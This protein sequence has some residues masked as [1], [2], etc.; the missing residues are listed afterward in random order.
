MNPYGDAIEDHWNP[1]F[2]AQP[3]GGDARYE[4]PNSAYWRPHESES[5]PVA[6]GHDTKPPLGYSQTRIGS[7][8]TLAYTSA[9]DAP[10]W[11]VPTRAMSYGHI[12]TLAHHDYQ[13]RAAAQF[14]HPHTLDTSAAITSTTISTPLSAPIIGHGMPNYGYQQQWNSVY[15][16]PASLPSDSLQ[17]Q[18]QAFAPQFYPTNNPHSLQQMKEEHLPGTSQYAGTPGFYQA[19]DSQVMR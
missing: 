1:G 7:V 17:G 2:F 8:S 5:S 12:E 6:Y 11:T 18:G 19:P 9:D 13:D 16:T 4:S 14:P 10:T 15:R 3:L